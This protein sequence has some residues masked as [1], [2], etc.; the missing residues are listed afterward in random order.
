MGNIE[1]NK[2]NLG[3]LKNIPTS[4][5]SKLNISHS[6][7]ATNNDSEIEV[8]IISGAS[9]SE[10]SKIVENLNGKYVDL[11]YGY[12]IVEISIENLV[13]LANSPEIQYIELPKSLYADDYESNR[14][15]CITQL[16][17]SEFNG[18]GVLVGFIDT[19]I[20]YT[21]PAFRNSDGTTRIEYIYDLNNGGKVYN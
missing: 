13:A 2:N 14:A 3:I 7:L 4:I 20:D 6:F 5:L 15:S 17:S 19:G 9:T 12:G 11:G 1:N 10:V 16:N 21:H 8:S 18:K